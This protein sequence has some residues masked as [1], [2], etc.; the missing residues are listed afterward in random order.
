MEKPS[1]EWEIEELTPS[2]QSESRENWL[3]SRGLRV[4][5]KILVAGVVISSA[6]LVLPP[7]LV[8]SAFGLAFSVPLGLCYVGYA[9]TKNLVRNLLPILPEPTPL[10]DGG[11]ATSDGEEENGEDN[12]GMK[13][14]DREERELVE[15]V[16]EK[17]KEEGY[18]EDDDEKFV[19]EDEK[20]LENIHVTVEGMGKE[21]IIEKII[22]DIDE[23]GK[24]CEYESFVSN[25]NGEKADGEMERTEEEEGN[26]GIPEGRGG[27]MDTVASEVKAAKEV[28]GTLEGKA[29]EKD[30]QIGL[31]NGALEEGGLVGIVGSMM[32]FEAKLVRDEKDVVEGAAAE[33]NNAADANEN[34]QLERKNKNGIRS[35]A[36]M[37]EIAVESGFDLFDQGTAPA[38]HTTT[39]FPLPDY[40]TLEGRKGTVV[41][42][43]PVLADEPD[44]EQSKVAS[45]RNSTAISFHE[46]RA[47]SIIGFLSPMKALLKRFNAMWPMNHTY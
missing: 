21:E 31:K 40:E 25:G 43:L 46:F 17:L 18:V 5:K 8:F 12:E 28:E 36:E 35:D 27:E 22:S 3:L 34:H 11:R 14:D 1:G 29:K 2:E 7:L 39:E 4:G 33:D 9:Y 24:P 19:K 38:T 26:E 45:E 42:E 23:I 16:D 41:F 13:E 15:N 37:R 44:S 30:V 6:P 20:P 10:A 32:E 47:H